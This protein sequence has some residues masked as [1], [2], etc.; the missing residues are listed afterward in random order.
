MNENIPRRVIDTFRL[1]GYDVVSVRETM[2]GASDVA[3]L[4]RAQKEKRILITNDKDFGELAFKTGLPAE[5]GVILFRLSST[6]P[7]EYCTRVTEVIEKS[8]DFQ[9]N[10]CVVTEERIRLRSLIKKE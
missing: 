4:E 7:E 5:C 6:T 8:M 9:G 1:K 10:F 3:V 2:K